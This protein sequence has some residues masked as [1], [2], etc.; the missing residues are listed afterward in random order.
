MMLADVAFVMLGGPVIVG[1]E[2]STPKRPMSKHCRRG[3]GRIRGSGARIRELG[4]AHCLPL[5]SA[6][7]HS[8]SPPPL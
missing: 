1:G 8:E 5:A 3:K 7:E 4:G 6:A 2:R